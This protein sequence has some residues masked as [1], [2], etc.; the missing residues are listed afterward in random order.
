MSNRHARARAAMPDWPLWHGIP[1][2]VPP[3]LGPRPAPRTAG[4]GQAAGSGTLN[5]LPRLESAATLASRDPR[6]TSPHSVAPP[7]A[8]NQHSYT[9]LKLSAPAPAPAP[10]RSGLSYALI[11]VV[12]AVAVSAAVAAF[13]LLHHTPRTQAAAATTR[14][15]AARQS[16]PTAPQSSMP[17]TQAVDDLAA[18]PI[19]HYAGELVSDAGNDDAPT[20]WDVY[21][22]AGGDEVGTETLNG[23]Q[24]GMLV[25]NETAYFQAP[26]NLLG[27]SPVGVP[28]SALQNTW[29][30]GDSALA[31]SV[32]PGLDTPGALATELRG[33]SQTAVGAVYLSTTS[34]YSIVRVDS[35]TP[36][37]ESVSTEL[38]PMTEDAERAALSTLIA[39]TR[40]LA[41]AMDLAVRFESRSAQ[42]L[43]CSAGTCTVTEQVGA[44]IVSD[45]QNT[46][47]SDSQPGQ[48]NAVM[49][50]VF[51]DADQANGSCS[52][53]SAVPTGGSTVVLSCTCAITGEVTREAL[54]SEQASLT[55]EAPAV[56]QGEIGQLVAQ[57]QNTLA[58]I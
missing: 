16:V 17:F 22:T 27:T 7:T 9:P 6:P 45:W 43:E 33:A 54:S 42:P 5:A 21:V 46:P 26:E 13:G 50:V 58:E 14:S 18:L 30:T 57:E 47:Q 15:S 11:T 3:Q 23:E 12:T 53:S 49:S 20:S 24:V 1:R 52:Q 8:A 51:S 32:P 34:P 40:Q 28:A 31:A 56:T 48:V 39:D 44:S 38:E 55:I 4:A 10:T 37:G 25:V 29:V 19:V 2:M 41:S 35:V 36:T